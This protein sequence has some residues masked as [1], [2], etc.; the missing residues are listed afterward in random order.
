MSLKE[1]SYTALLTLIQTPGNILISHQPHATMILLNEYL[2]RL[3]NV[4]GS[5]E[6]IYQYLH[7]SVG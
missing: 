2:K 4:F 1:R 5:P 7:L 6:A 3:N